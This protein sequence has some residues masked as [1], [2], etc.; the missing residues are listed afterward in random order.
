MTFH[1]DKEFVDAIDAS[2]QHFK[3]HPALIEKDYWVTYVLRNLSKSDFVAKVVFKGGTS[4]SKAFHCIERF[5]EDIDLAL[6]NEEKQS[7]D[8]CYK[9]MKKIEPE[10]TKE[11][12]QEDGEPGDKMAR[13]RVTYYS[14]DKKS[15]GEV[16]AVK[17]KIQL[18]INTFTNPV[19]HD[20]KEI[21]SY[22]GQF[23]KLQ[24]KHDLISNHGLEPFT[25]LVLTRERTF[26]EK[27]LSLIRLSYSGNDK[28]KEK[29]RHFY[30][31]FMLYK[32]SDLG[33]K[34]FSSDNFQ[35]INLALQ[36]DASNKIF[37]GDWMNAKLSDSPLFKD[38]S[39]TWKELETTFKNELGQL[40]WNNNL[41]SS[42]EIVALL[43]KIK[44]FL[45]EFDEA[46]PPEKR[47]VESN[48]K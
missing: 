44:T 40:V 22:V 3:I 29:I 10:I 31:L 48:S 32:Q 7:D 38:P 39:A 20:K 45:I 47:I 34:L 17:D 30:D 18:E 4:L 21:Q 13:K 36:D 2:S 5:S 46:Y 14:Y 37:S 35:L 24:G 43:E 23:L 33:D 27:L 11:L 6:L 1:N 12:K 26:F 25:L 19:P 9:L 41:P 15:K 28:L 42:D 8:K 16:K